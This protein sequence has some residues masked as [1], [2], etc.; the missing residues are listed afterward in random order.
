MQIAISIYD[1]V[2]DVTALEWASSAADVTVGEGDF[3]NTSWWAYGNCSSGAAY[4][5]VDPRR[6]CYPQIIHFNKTHPDNWDSGLTGRK[7]VACHELGHTLGLRHA[8]SSQSSCMRN[9]Q[10]IYP[11][12]T[13][14]DK[15]MLNG[16]Y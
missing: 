4:G 1:D 12:I 16:L 14:H 15:A 5:G 11:T 8:V 6:W 10:T 9:A 13:D 3:G 2:T 7:T